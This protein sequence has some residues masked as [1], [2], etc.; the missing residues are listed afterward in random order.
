VSLLMLTRALLVSLLL[1]AI[2]VPAAAIRAEERAEQR[3]GYYHTFAGE[4]CYPPPCPNYVGDAVRSSFRRNTLI[5]GIRSAV[6]RSEMQAFVPA[7]SGAASSLTN[8]GTQVSA[9]GSR[10]LSNTG[11]S[12]SSAHAGVTMDGLKRAT[13][14]SFVGRPDYGGFSYVEKSGVYPEWVSAKRSVKINGVFPKMSGK[15]ARFKLSQPP[16]KPL[17]FSLVSGCG[18]TP[19]AKKQ[20]S[21]EWTTESF[22][23]VSKHLRKQRV[24]L[25][26]H[27]NWV[28]EATP[29]A[30]GIRRHVDEVR[31]WQA[32]LQAE[33]TRLLASKARAEEKMAADRAF[34]VADEKRIIQERKDALVQ[35]EKAEA[36][37]KAQ[38]LKAK[39]TVSKNVEI[40]V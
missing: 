12:H 40:R 3:D 31:R 5:N 36:E 16:A 9:D 30:L 34:I 7:G 22:R 8:V 23:K 18:E 4:P 29:V 28:A 20:F 32:D 10:L 13:S 14:V 26:L 15:L 37:A 35:R 33:L 1:A 17:P 39:T 21:I 24:A 19:C 38:A 25:L 6:E 11:H 2:L 27:E